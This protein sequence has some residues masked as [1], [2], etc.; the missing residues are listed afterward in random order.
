MNCNSALV[1]A[2]ICGCLLP[3]QT[4]LNTILGEYANGAIFG[5]LGAFIVG[6]AAIVMLLQV[7]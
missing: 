1:L 6:L 7:G 3:V 4:A 5:A 2:L